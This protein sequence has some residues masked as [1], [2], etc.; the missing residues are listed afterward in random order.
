MPGIHLLDRLI[1]D[2]YPSFLTDADIRAFEQTPYSERI[3]ADST[4]DAI[5]LGAANNEPTPQTPRKSRNMIE[6]LRAVHLAR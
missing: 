1:G 6:R 3:A 5:R 4:Y 2:E